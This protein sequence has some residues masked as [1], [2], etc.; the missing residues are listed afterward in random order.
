M[1]LI[2]VWGLAC[3]AEEARFRWYLMRV[4][5]GSAVFREFDLPWVV[6]GA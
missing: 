3:V 5:M 1:G 6:Y 4:D 2:R